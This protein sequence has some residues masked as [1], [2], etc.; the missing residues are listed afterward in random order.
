MGWLIGLNGLEVLQGVFGLKVQSLTLWAFSA[1]I[2]GN[3]P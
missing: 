2:E 1:L 3:D